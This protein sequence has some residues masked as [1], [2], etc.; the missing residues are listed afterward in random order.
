MF[1]SL[2]NPSGSEP[3]NILDFSTA[4]I[5][6]RFLV[7]F[8]TLLHV[9]YIELLNVVKFDSLIKTGEK[10]SGFSIRKAS[11]MQNNSVKNVNT[12]TKCRLY[13]Y[14]GQKGAEGDVLP[15]LDVPGGP[16]VH[17]DHA[18]DV[19]LRRLHPDWPTQGRRLAAHKEGHLQ[20]EVHEAAGAEDRRFGVVRARL[21]VRPVD[22]CPLEKNTHF[23]TSRY[24]LPVLRIRIRDPGPF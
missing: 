12:T 11:S 19:L 16:V 15:L 1:R 24:K 18:E 9:S 2:R 13:V 20:L 17:D 3:L 21:A 22:R 8:N 14:L 6:V 4:Y 5:V 23:L 10:I 7:R